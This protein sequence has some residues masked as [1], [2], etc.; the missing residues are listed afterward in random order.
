MQGNPT[1]KAAPHFSQQEDAEEL[2]ETLKLAS[3]N[4]DVLI[5]I[6]CHRNLEQRL[7]SQCLNFSLKYLRQ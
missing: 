6:L 7:V 5:N 2:L 1:V 3:P 4:K